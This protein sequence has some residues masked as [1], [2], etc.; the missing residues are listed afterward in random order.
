V[1][2]SIPH[3]DR[4]VHGRSG[5]MNEGISFLARYILTAKN[6]GNQSPDFTSDLTSVSDGSNMKC[7]EYRFHP[8]QACPRYL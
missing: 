2:L 5:V 8:G 3:F 6:L 7:G 4:F 1:E